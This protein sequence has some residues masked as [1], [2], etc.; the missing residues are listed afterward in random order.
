MML[1]TT[2][3]AS[4]WAPATTDSA[5]RWLRLAVL[6]ILGTALIT[7]SAKTSVPFYP[8]PMT[9]QTLAIS[10]IAAAYGLR[11]GVATV[12]LYLAEAALGLPVLAGPLP[13]YAYFTGPTAGFLVGF[14]LMAAIIGAAADRGF[15]RKPLLIFGAMLVANIAVFVPGLIGLSLVFPSLGFADLIAKGAMPFALATLVKTLLA[16]AIMPAS[17]ALVKRLNG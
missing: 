15:D 7:L 9:L 1:N 10:V 5:T 2:L 16:A 14:V 4:L 17:W 6:A 11:L 3:A 13:G 12:L 8:V